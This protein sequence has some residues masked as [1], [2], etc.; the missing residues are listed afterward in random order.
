[1]KL[2]KREGYEFIS[3]EQ[4]RE[5][6]NEGLNKIIHA[7]GYEKI[8][9]TK[10]EFYCLEDDIRE[11]IN[12][13]LKF[14]FDISYYSGKDNSSKEVK[15]HIKGYL[16][17][18][19]NEFLHCTIEDRKEEIEKSQPVIKA[20]KELIREVFKEIRQENEKITGLQTKKTVGEPLAL[21][22]MKAI[23]NELDERFL[24]K[25][26]SKLE[27]KDWSEEIKKELMKLLND[28]LKEC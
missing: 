14:L 3:G 24:S 23:R 26:K 19:L 16:F 15:E 5:E 13:T 4:Q 10:D 21:N 9:M 22:E 1:M 12:D 8:E 6:F 20:Y 27:T 17:E 7:L 18:V 11:V 2:V 28:N 25:A